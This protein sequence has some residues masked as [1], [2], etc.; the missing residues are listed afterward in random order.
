M[1]SYWDIDD[2]DDEIGWAIPPFQ[3]FYAGVIERETEKAVLFLPKKF[4]GPVW[5]PKS[6]IKEYTK[7]GIYITFWI[8]LKKGWI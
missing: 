2:Y 3:L 6:Q 5:I 4:N 7:N 1:E 8:A